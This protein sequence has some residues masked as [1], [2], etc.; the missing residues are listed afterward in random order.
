MDADTCTQGGAVMALL[1]LVSESLPFISTTRCQGLLH[2]IT[3][4]LIALARRTEYEGP[5]TPEADGTPDA[6]AT[7]ADN[8][9]GQEPTH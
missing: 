5:S 4:V 1:L 9:A 3:G 2:A 6:D 7:P 8:A